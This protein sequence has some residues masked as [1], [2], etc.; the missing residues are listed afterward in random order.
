MFENLL[1]QPDQNEIIMDLLFTMTHWQ[2]LAKLRLHTDTTL[3]IL[4]EVTTQLGHQLRR[5][6]DKL[7]PQFKTRALPKEIEAEKRCAAVSSSSKNSETR[8]ANKK[9]NA[10]MKFS[11]STFKFHSHGHVVEDIRRF[12]TT[13]LYSTGPVSAQS[14]IFLL[15]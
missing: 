13:D 7:C 8:A 9:Q 1:S 5:F 12:G 2:A 15:C 11:L 10:I 3:F 14:G 6:R 4:D